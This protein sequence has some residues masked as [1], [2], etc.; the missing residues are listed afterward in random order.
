MLLSNVRDDA[1]GLSAS[2][3]SEHPRASITPTPSPNTRT[4]GDAIGDR[5]RY[6]NW[7]SSDH[8]CE[9]RDGSLQGRRGFRFRVQ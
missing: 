9:R 2:Q 1:M 3:R 4:L 8:S 6:R 7:S 5:P